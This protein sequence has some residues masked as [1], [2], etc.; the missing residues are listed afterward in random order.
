MSRA[1][2]KDK[3]ADGRGKKFD[4]TAAGIRQIDPK[5]MMKGRPPK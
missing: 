3:P 5:E 1:K 2:K 4:K